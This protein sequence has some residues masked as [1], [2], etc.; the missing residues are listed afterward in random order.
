MKNP[1]WICESCIQTFTRKWNAHR[2]CKTKH[3]HVVGSIILFNEYSA[4]NGNNKPM[5]LNEVYPAGSIYRKNKQTNLFLQNG[6]MELSQSQSKSLHTK[7]EDNNLNP[8]VLLYKVLSS[9]APKYQQLRN[10]LSN[11]PEQDKKKIL[12][13][14]LLR[15]FQSDDPITFI[16]KELEWLAKIKIGNDMINDLSHTFELDRNI[17]KKFLEMRLRSF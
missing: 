4:K 2:H 13:T 8:E 11:I 1:K 5:Y 7:E 12:S 10:L 9:I 6:L 15:A 16:S 17:I 3:H 14:I